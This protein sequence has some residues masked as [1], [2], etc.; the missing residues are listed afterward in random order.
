MSAVIS[1]LNTDT[2][3]KLDDYVKTLVSKEFDQCMDEK[4]EG[5]IREI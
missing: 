5:K 3:E 1:E 2:K 4:L